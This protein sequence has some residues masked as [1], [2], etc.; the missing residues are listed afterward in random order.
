MVGKPAKPQNRSLL[1]DVEL[2]LAHGRRK[3]GKWGGGGIFIYSCYAQLICFE[4]KILK[5]I[6]LTVYEQEYMNMCPP[7]PLPHY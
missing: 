2:Y 1:F 5:S 4:I 7:P 3:I 6:V